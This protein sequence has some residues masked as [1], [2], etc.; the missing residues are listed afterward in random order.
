MP[1]VLQV[2]ESVHGRTLL[3]SKD[4]PARPGYLDAQIVL[5]EIPG[6]HPYVT[7]Q[8]NVRDGDTYWGHYFS[9]RREAEADFRKRVAEKLRASF[10]VVS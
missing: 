5:M 1:R 9:T 4:L 7:W 3:A 8:R 10:E 2:G 6:H